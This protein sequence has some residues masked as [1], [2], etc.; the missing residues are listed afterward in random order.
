M[1]E[2]FSIKTI[3]RKCFSQLY[4]LRMSPGIPK[5]PGIQIKMTERVKRRKL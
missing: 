2:K 3:K 5:G 4:R 1:K